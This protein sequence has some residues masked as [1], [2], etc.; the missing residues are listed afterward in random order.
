MIS[1][2]PGLIVHEGTRPL[3][4]RPCASRALKV[5]WMTSPVRA[6]ERAG[7]TS[8]RATAA[9]STC[10][11]TVAVAA[12]VLTEMVARPGAAAR[13]TPSSDTFTT[14]GAELVHAKVSSRRSPDCE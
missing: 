11:G 3:I 14:P 1:P 4:S 12:P 8:S 9:V 13:S 5:N 2:P 10:T 7:V 6:S